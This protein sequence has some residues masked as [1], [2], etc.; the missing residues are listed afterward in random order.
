MVGPDLLRTSEGQSSQR[1]WERWRTEGRVVSRDEEQPE[2][3]RFNPAIQPKCIILF[4]ELKERIVLAPA[5]LGV[6]G[7]RPAMESIYAGSENVSLGLTSSQ[8]K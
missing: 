3:S 6:T 7:G 8:G 2:P 5:L 1:R 4:K